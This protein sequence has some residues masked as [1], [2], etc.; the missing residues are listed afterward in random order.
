MRA[1]FL[2]G[3]PRL[4]PWPKIFVTRMLTRDLFA[5][6]D[7]LIWNLITTGDSGFTARSAPSAGVFSVRHVR[8]L[9]P[10]VQQAKDIVKLFSRLGDRCPIIP[11]F[12]TQSAVTQFPGNPISGGVKYTPSVIGKMRFSTESAVYF[13]NGTG[14]RTK[15]KLRD[16]MRKRGT[17]RWPV[18]VSPSHSCIVCKQLNVIIGIFLG[19]ITSSFQVSEFK[20]RFTI[21]R[22]T[23]LSG[24]DKQTWVQK[25]L[26]FSVNISLYLGNSRSYARV[27]HWTLVGSHSYPRSVRIS[28]ED[29]EWLERQERE[30][31]FF[32]WGGISIRT[33]IPFNQERSNLARLPMWGRG[34]FVRVQVRSL[35]QGA[36]PQRSPM[37][38]VFLPTQFDAERPNSAW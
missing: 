38:G 5:V 18:S 1:K 33:L 30:G 22:G 25:I 35:P 21:Q 23:S 4:L 28:S 19:H 11:V 10:N 29:L 34:V 36:G 32:S 13:G 2:Y 16:A 31:Q 9:Y 6:A 3:R 12:L 7:H 27:Y 17:S 8:L 15:L 37:L 14:T 26:Q 20:R 24:G